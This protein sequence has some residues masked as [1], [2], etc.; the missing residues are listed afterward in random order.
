MLPRT[1]QWKG[2]AMRAEY[3]WFMFVFNLITMPIFLLLQVL[4]VL[5]SSEFVVVL[6]W[7]VWFI[8]YAICYLPILF[9]S[10]RRMHDLGH[11]GFWVVLCMGSLSIVQGMPQISGF[12]EP[13]IFAIILFFTVALSLYLL[14]KDGER[15]DNKYGED[16]KKVL[17]DRYSDN[18]NSK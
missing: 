13:A 12:S 11:S 10:I 16:P 7:F 17:I 9:V 6:C 4:A 2:R 1:F 15:K 14:F 5:N 18:Q 3:F 8:I